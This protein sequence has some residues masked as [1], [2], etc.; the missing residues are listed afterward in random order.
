MGRRGTLCAIGVMT[1]ALVIGGLHASPA[2]A[3]RTV[4]QSVAESAAGGDELKVIL[5]LDTSGSMRRPGGSGGTLLQGAK[6]AVSELAFSLPPNTRVGLRTYGSEYAGTNRRRSCRDTRLLVPVQRLNPQKLVRA[7]RDLRPTGDTPIGY[8]LQRA[9]SDLRGGK[10]ERRVV[11]LIS[12]GEDNCSP[13]G[14]APCQVAA[15][16]KRANVTLRVE[17]IGFALRGQRSARRALRCI[18][19]RTGGDYYDAENADALSAAL[20]R[21]ASQTLG[22]LGRGKQVS[23]GDRLGAGPLLEPGA[24]RFQLRAGESK[25]FRIEVEEGQRPR[26][27]A[28]VQGLDRLHIPRGARNCPAWRA[29]L[30]NPYGEGGVYPPY[31]N[32]GL[33]DG[34]GYGTTGA[35]TARPVKRYPVGIDY[36]GEW[37]VRL[38]LAEDTQDTCSAHFPEN[39]SFTARFSIE[40]GEP[41]VADAQEPA[42]P[43][44]NPSAATN[45]GSA[46]SGADG[47][48]SGRSEAAKKFDTPVREGAPAWVTP[49]AG[50]GGLLLLSGAAGGFLIWLRK[51][52]R[53]W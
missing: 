39:A 30:F 27:L 37:A 48:A 25:W 8:S 52:R 17:S 9:A 29:E 18:S 20:Q 34:V 33:F 14:P 19:D 32:S 51:R 41:A 31:G 26:V 7:V 47:D 40:T 6:R 15:G 21:I 3:A 13:P 43:A 50:V 38:V 53:G 35:S 49:V 5:V 12:D 2:S 16:L 44:P 1:F 10:A 46:D 45:E 42:S 4:A 24:Y 28:T 11:V 23:G 22:R 36:A